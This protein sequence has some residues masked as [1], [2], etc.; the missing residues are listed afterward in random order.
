MTY[1]QTLCTP[2]TLLFSMY[3]SYWSYWICTNLLENIKL[4]E[5]I[6]LCIQCIA[7]K[8]IRESQGYMEMT[9]SSHSTNASTKR[10]LIQHDWLYQRSS[11][12]KI[13]IKVSVRRHKCFT[14]SSSSLKTVWRHQLTS[15]KSSEIPSHHQRKMCICQDKIS[16]YLMFLEVFS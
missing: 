14:A 11:L 16:A 3:E 4:G 1:E 6:I 2:L 9:W 5:L 8:N 15:S 7:I 10:A 12:P 13:L